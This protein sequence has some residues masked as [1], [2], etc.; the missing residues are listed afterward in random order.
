MPATKGARSARIQGWRRR[1]DDRGAPAPKV[2][3]RQHGTGGIWRHWDRHCPNG[4]TAAPRS[5]RSWEVHLHIVGFPPDDVAPD[6]YICTSVAIQALLDEDAEL[7]RLALGIWGDPTR[8]AKV[9]EM[10]GPP[11]KAKRRQMQKIEDKRQAALKKPRQEARAAFRA[12]ED[13]RVRKVAEAIANETLPLLV[14]RHQHG[15]TA[16]ERIPQSA[17]VRRITHVGEAWELP[18]ALR[19]GEAETLRLPRRYAEYGLQRGGLYFRVNDWNRLLQ[20]QGIGG[21]RSLYRQG[22][23]NRSLDDEA[24]VSEVRHAVQS[25]VAKSYREASESIP[26]ERMPGNGTPENRRRRVAQKAA[27]LDRSGR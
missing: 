1:Y 26:I 22:G 25:K 15:Q 13:A 11:S 27:K 24:V 23:G 17:L 9:S 3:Y 7:G 19:T 4:K 16:E 10:E 6:G 2:A 20:L 14:L 5:S 8:A 21:R 18:R 12:A